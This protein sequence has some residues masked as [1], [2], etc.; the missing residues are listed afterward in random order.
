MTSQYEVK[1]TQM[2]SIFN[3]ALSYCYQESI[4]KVAKFVQIA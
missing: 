2:C 1:I 3:H 4:K